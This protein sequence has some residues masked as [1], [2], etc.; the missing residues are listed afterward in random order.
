M[1][2]SFPVLAL[3]LVSRAPVAAAQCSP[4]DWMTIA[5][6]PTGDSIETALETAYPGLNLDWEEGILT[7]ASGETIQVLPARDVDPAA[8]LVD[9]TLGDQFFY[10]YPL[11][12]ALTARRTA[13]HDPGRLRNDTFFR[14][15][16]F[17]SSSEARASL[18]TVSYDGPN[19]SV[20]FSVTQDY[21]V[22]VQLDAA[23][24]E[25][26]AL[27]PDYAVYFENSGGSFNWRQIAGTNRLSVHSF[28]IAVDLNTALG[29]YWRWSGAAQGQA[30]EYDN[31]IPQE[32]VEAFERY[33]F[34]WGGKWHHFDGMHFE[35]RPELI[36]HA[37]LMG[38]G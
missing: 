19:G 23:L 25:I 20:R 4:V 29:G 1:R 32:I 35:Y 22:D 15:L 28:G 5:L 6:P 30:A 2:W 7:L 17:D 33:G 24:D 34:I 26:E 11:D 27:G 13:F 31:R 12:F 36:L 37:R 3:I 18:T 16:Y 21:C 9:A 10:T 38:Q 14:T 8:R